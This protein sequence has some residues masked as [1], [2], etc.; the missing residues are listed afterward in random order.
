MAIYWIVSYS[1][2]ILCFF[3]LAT[4]NQ[5]NEPKM[6]RV[7]TYF[8]FIA[9]V[10]LIMFAG[11]RGPNS[12]ID[13]WQYLGFF[14]DFSR[15]SSISGY[16]TVADIY[17]YE[18]LFM[19]LAWVLSWFTHESYFFL[20]FVSFIAVST[21]AWIFKKYS[22]LIL[23]SLCL[24]SAHLFINK[25]MNQIR[26]G[27]SSAFAV[28]CICSAAGRKYFLAFVFLAFST[29]SHSTGYAVLMVLPFLFL[30]ERKYFGIAM[31]LAAIPLG[32]I[33][34]KKLFLD[35]LGIVPVIGDRAMGYSGTVFDAASPVFGL[36][37]LKNI[38][39][40]AFFTVV[41]FN[42][43]I[44]EE[45]RIAYILFIAYSA[46]AA[47]RIV[48]SDFS[49]IGGRVGNLFLHCEPL[50]LAFLMMRIRHTLLNF[51]LLFAMTSYYLAYNTI[52]S[53]QSI[54]GYSIAPLFRLF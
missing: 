1:I 34:G 16:E 45:D 15:Q 11:F 21:N 51:G 19:L 46:G 20:L 17:R 38:A 18:N 54:N 23:C 43:P 10:A 47:V 30:R 29:Q 53:V 35:S 24:Y 42:R 28:A 36:A 32:L 2:L 52:L 48:F 50:L 39:F 41:Y 8:F 13:D 27:L 33:G 22:P 3:E 5:A 25:D 7:T 26:F 31:V 12:G 37:N 6:K 9:V 44:K 14:Y 40:I 4:I 49:I